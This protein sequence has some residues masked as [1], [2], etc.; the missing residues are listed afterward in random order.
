MR[1][2]KGRHHQKGQYSTGQWLHYYFEKRTCR[3]KKNPLYCKEEMDKENGTKDQ[4]KH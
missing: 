3:L 1:A 2:K 4:F